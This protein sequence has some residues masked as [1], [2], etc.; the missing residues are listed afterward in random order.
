MAPTLFQLGGGLRDPQSSSHPPS[1]LGSMDPTIM[2]KSVFR[3]LLCLMLEHKSC[4]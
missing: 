3:K 1:M 4:E 2:S